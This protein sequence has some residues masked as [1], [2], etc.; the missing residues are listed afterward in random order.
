MTDNIN[1]LGR[2][3]ENLKLGDKD[4]LQ[5]DSGDKNQNDKETKGNND[6]Q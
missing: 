2:A 4:I 5:I 3:I 6:E 1:K